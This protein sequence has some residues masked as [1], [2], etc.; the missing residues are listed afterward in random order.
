MQAAAAFLN[1]TSMCSKNFKEK[2]EMME[3]INYLLEFMVAEE[4]KVSFM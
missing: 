2:D 3:G 4:E 1:P